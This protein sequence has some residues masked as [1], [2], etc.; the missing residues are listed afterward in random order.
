MESSYYVLQGN[1]HYGP[2]LERQFKKLV[3]SGTIKADA[4][5]STSES[6]PWVALDQVDSLP[7]NAVVVKAPGVYVSK[8][9]AGF[10]G[11]GGIQGYPETRPAEPVNVTGIVGF[12]LSICSLLTCGLLFP[13]SLIVSVFAVFKRP[14][15][16]ATAGIAVSCLSA[17][18][19]LGAWYAIYS[20]GN[21]VERVRVAARRDIIH[22]KVHEFYRAN[23]RVP[24]KNE[25]QGFVRA[26]LSRGFR[27]HSG[28]NSFVRLVHFGPDERFDTS[29]DRLY[30]FDAK[31]APKRS[32]KSY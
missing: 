15:G 32:P 29:D 14:K 7:F 25:Y 21:Q 26:S 20:I 24:T 13:I 5:V 16:F 1:E 11:G 30:K 6:G 17:I 9:S 8:E 19:L 10:A 2:Y 18:L 12:V 31:L 3:S 23:M 28:S 27:Y 4:K 22:Q